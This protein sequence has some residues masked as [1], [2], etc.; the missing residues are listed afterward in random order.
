MA[1][2][3]GMQLMPYPGVQALALAMAGAAGGGGSAEPWQRGGR[4]AEATPEQHGE[5]GSEEQTWAAAL[6]ALIS[7][8][9]R[10]RGRFLVLPA[11]ELSGGS[12]GGSTPS[13]SLAEAL[14]HATSP[15]RAQARTRESNSRPLSVSDTL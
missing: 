10:E 4:A 2:G 12:D 6:R 15:T 1:D 8:T 3:N 14:V 13:A 7:T 11:L 5:E 9:C